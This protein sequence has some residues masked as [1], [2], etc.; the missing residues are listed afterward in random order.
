MTQRP[1]RLLDQVRDAI[2]LKHYAHSP[3]TSNFHLPLQRAE[4]G[5]PRIDRRFCCG[6]LI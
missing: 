4:G 1:K 5:Q 2:W 3:P 6:G